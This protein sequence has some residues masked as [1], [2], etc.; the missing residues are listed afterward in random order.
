MEKPYH[1]TEIKHLN[2]GKILSHIFPNEPKFTICKGN[3]IEPAE[4]EREDIIKA[5]HKSK[6]NFHKGIA[7]TFDKIRKQYN[8]KNLKM[9]VD[10][11][12]KQ[13]TTCNRNKIHRQS[14]TQP[15]ILTDTLTKPFKRINID[16]FEY[17][18]QL[19]LTIRD[20]FSKYTQAYPL[21]NKSA[22]EVH[23]KLLLYFRHYGKPEQIYSDNGLEFKNSLIDNMC[24]S[25]N[26][27]QLFTANRHPQA[28]GSLER[29]HATLAE[30][31]RI[32]REEYPKAS[33]EELINIDIIAYNYSTTQSTG[34]T[35]HYILFGHTQSQNP[36][37][38]D[39][40]RKIYTD[41]ALNHQSKIEHIYRGVINKTNISKEK[42]KERFDKTTKQTTY[43]VNDYV[44]VKLQNK[45]K[46]PT[47]SQRSI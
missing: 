10:R 16:I 34:Y 47:T 39:T 1:I 11:Y 28:N 17:S 37:E 5:Y 7:E 13:C 46:K 25:Y 21:P 2:L 40:T 3:I 42:A 20:E 31:L 29:F 36:L 18:K 14:T 38:N 22:K 12:I 15:L 33:F 26:I 41:Y 24:E 30:S 6:T 35:P 8:W 43:Q 44:Y 19:V 32:G 27:R 9:E 23:D 4:D 45:L